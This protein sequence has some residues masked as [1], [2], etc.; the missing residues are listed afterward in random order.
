M[1]FAQWFAA[2]RRRNPNAKLNAN[3]KDD[4]LRRYNNWKA[5]NP[6]GNTTG[7]S[8]SAGSA[9]D[10]RTG[11]DAP[12]A[13][14]PGADTPEPPAPVA[15]APPPPP[16][17]ARRDAALEQQILNLVNDR[18]LLPAKY[19]QQRNRAATGF[20]SGLLDGGFFDTIDIG[21]EEKT[22]DANGNPLW[23]PMEFREEAGTPQQNRVS[24]QAVQNPD[25]S[26]RPEGN[27]TYKFSYGPDGRIYR[28]AFMG[29]AN[30]FA[31]RG[32][33]GSLV[34][35]AQRQS[36][37]AIDTARDQSMRNYNNTVE[38]IRRNQGT[39][40]TNLTTAITTGN[41]AYQGWSGT[42]DVTMP[43]APAPSAAPADASGANNAVTPNIP[44]PPQGNLGTW[45]VKAAGANAAPRLTRQVKARNPGVNFRIVRQGNRYVAVRT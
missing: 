11:T 20:R 7:T 10:A 2:Y 36:R 38:D 42:Q 33:S 5:N 21:S 17:A 18:N 25:Q 40:D 41:T 45:T 1:D 37:Q 24:L 27:V 3:T 32:V 19:N 12:G 9:W 39:E 34:R 8:T 31:A 28:Q 6:S 44:T 15:P 14:T 26:K 16:A 13:G 23:R 35:D 29:N 43:A 4:L 22:T 30:A